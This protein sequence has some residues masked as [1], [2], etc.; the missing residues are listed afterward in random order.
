IAGIEGATD[1]RV[2]TPPNVT[3]LAVVPDPLLAAQAGLNARNVLDAVTAIRV[4][5]PVGTTWEGPIEIPILLHV[6]RETSAFELG[7]HPI[8][9]EGGRL[10]PLSSVAE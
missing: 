2:T 7:R 6:G 8:V 9:A 4:G 1:V 10:V 5:L 3:M